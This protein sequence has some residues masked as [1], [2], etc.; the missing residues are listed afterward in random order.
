MS[1]FATRAPFAN[2]IWFISSKKVPVG[3]RCN[4]HNEKNNQKFNSKSKFSIILKQDQNINPSSSFIYNGFHM[5][6]GNFCLLNGHIPTEFSCVVT[7]AMGYVQHL[8]LAVICFVPVTIVKTIVTADCLTYHFT[9]I[10]FQGFVI[11]NTEENGTDRIPSLV[12][13]AAYLRLLPR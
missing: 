10:N 13:H 7:M 5:A 4:F 8:H 12:C 11:K 9:Q 6:R 3:R 1:I 2:L